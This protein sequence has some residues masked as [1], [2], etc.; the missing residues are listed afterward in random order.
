MDDTQVR[1]RHEFEAITRS[2]AT[3]DRLISL[4]TAY[5][6]RSLWTWEETAEATKRDILRGKS[7]EEIIRWY[8][9]IV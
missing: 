2:R 7:V 5:T 3:A 6:N 8:A 1:W 9:D 4:I